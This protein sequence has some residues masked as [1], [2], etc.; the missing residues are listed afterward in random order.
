MFEMIWRD[1]N[2][3]GQVIED[4]DKAMD[5]KKLK[6]EAERLTKLISGCD[7]RIS[8]LSETIDRLDPEDAAYDRKYDDMQ[9]RLDSLYEEREHLE[10][11]KE[12]VDDKMAARHDVRDT[13][14]RMVN[15]VIRVLNGLYQMDDEQK[16]VLYH[17]MFEHFELNPDA[18]YR[19]GEGRA[20]D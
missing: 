17:Q 12:A 13:I 14:E 8:K 2:L 15:D 3:F 20:H 11:E 4:T 6:D 18:D 5:M 7:R 10:D 16:S 1:K 19:K 9:A